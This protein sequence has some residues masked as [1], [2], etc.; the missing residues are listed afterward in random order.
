MQEE[1]EEDE[2]EEEEDDDDDDDDDGD[3]DNDAAAAD[4]DDGDDGGDGGDGYDDDGDDDDCPPRTPH[5]RQAQQHQYSSSSSP[6]AVPPSSRPPSP[7]SVL[8]PLLVVLLQLPGHLPS[9]QPRTTFVPTSS[10]YCCDDDDDQCDGATVTRTGTWTVSRN[11]EENS[12][13]DLLPFVPSVKFRGDRAEHGF[14]EP[15]T[16]SE[17]LSLL[18]LYQDL[19]LL[20]WAFALCFLPVTPEARNGKLSPARLALLAARKLW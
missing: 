7:P 19:L 1:E 11:H 15:V 2:E 9:C 18:G 16:A 17:G 5:E 20:T 14:E 13:G 3:D 6:P 10:C 8:P 4:D 12:A